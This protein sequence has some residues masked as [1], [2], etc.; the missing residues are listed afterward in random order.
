M[1][2]N[3]DINIIEATSYVGRI[4]LGPLQI[5]VLPKVRGKALLTLFRYAY[6]LRNLELASASDYDG[7]INQ[8]FQEVLV[9]QLTAE[10]EELLARGLQRGYRPLREP[11]ASPRGRFDFESYV[12]MGAPVRSTFPCVHYQRLT[13]TPINQVLLAGMQS[14][15]PLTTDLSLRVRMRRTIQQLAEGVSPVPL[16]QESLRTAYRSLDRQ[17]VAYQPALRIIHLLMQGLGLDLETGAA[18]KLPGFLYDMNRFFQALL[19]RFLHDFLPGVEIRDEH[20]LTGMMAYEAGFNPQRRQ[21]PSPRPDFV[22]LQANRII[23][24]LDA[25]YRDLWEHSL[26]REMLYQLSIYA[27]SQSAPMTAAILYPTTNSTAREA[28]IAI[29]D[30]VSR[31]EKGAVA[32]RPVDL[33]RLI[34][35]VEMPNT[36]AARRSREA[37]ATHLAYGR[38]VETL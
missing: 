28:R 29:H 26:P 32:L 38:E 8:A 27:L 11:L 36:L 22:L 9:L 1:L 20:R 17:T 21:A 25:K 34:E 5:T 30:P 15:L 24:V 19:S 6:G 3:Q 16:N 4:S 7:D 33:N 18:L 13:D 35:V 2:A 10:V 37:Y 31:Q 12:R 23:A 14:A